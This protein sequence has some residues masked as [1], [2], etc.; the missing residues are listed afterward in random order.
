MRFLNVLPA[1][2]VGGFLLLQAL[3]AQATVIGVSNLSFPGAVNGIGIKNS[4]YQEIATQFNTGAGPGWVLTSATVQIAKLTVDPVAVAAVLYSYNTGTFLPGVELGQS[5]VALI[6]NSGFNNYDLDFSSLGLILAPD[7]SY[8]LALRQT[9]GDINTAVWAYPSTSDW[10]LSLQ[11]LPGWSITDLKRELSGTSWNGY[12]DR[13]GLFSIN[14]VETGV[15]EPAT[16]SIIG[17]GF[18][19]MALL[20]RRISI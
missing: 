10:A 4:S 11:G 20:R 5:S 6:S 16:V 9:Q 18:V 3:P 8:Y 15:P 7:T 17:L 12:Q 2:A 14:V 1:V 19:G 13:P